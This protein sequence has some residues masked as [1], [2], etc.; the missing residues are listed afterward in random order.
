MESMSDK[1]VLPIPAFLAVSSREKIFFSNKTN[2]V[3]YSCL[4]F[5]FG[6][7]IQSCCLIYFNYKLTTQLPKF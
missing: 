7:N 6:E 4:K 1:T 5:M 3:L 2:I